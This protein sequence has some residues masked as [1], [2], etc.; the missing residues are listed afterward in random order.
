MP[1]LPVEKTQLIVRVPAAA[2][3]PPAHVPGAARDAIT[4]GE[5]SCTFRTQLVDR[6]F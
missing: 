3:D 4:I 1:V 6:G 2:A 5:L